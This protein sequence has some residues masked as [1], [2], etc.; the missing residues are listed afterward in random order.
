MHLDIGMAV[1]KGSK[2]CCQDSV[3]LFI[4]EVHL[5]TYLFLA[6]FFNRISSLQRQHGLWLPPSGSHSS[7]LAISKVGE[8]FSIN[9]R[10][11]FMGRTL[12]GLNWVITQFS[13]NCCGER[14]D[15]FDW[16]NLD[17]MSLSCGQGK[18]ESH[19]DHFL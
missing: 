17:H 6:S 2:Q 16:L 4:S 5:F 14:M 15:Y 10:G 12:L 3:S 13:I 7:N 1:S 11:K 9:S 18:V 19:D 8:L